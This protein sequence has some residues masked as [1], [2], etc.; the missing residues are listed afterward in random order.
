MKSNRFSV[1]RLRSTRHFSITELHTEAFISSRSH[2]GAPGWIARKGN[3][4]S[5]ER[6]RVPRRHQEAGVFFANDL[7]NRPE[8]ASD[9]GAGPP[10]RFEKHESE[11]FG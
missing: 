7:L 6:R 9:D 5:S 1:K 4:R 10:H 3:D 2:R 8:R 11:P